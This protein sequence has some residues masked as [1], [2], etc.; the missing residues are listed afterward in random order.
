MKYKGIEG[1]YHY[2]KD[3]KMFV[4]ELKNTTYLVTFTG[5]SPK[6]IQQSFK[7]AV[8]SYLYSLKKDDM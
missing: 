5:S 4:G 8:E 2:N 6:D 7:S 3:M 1:Q